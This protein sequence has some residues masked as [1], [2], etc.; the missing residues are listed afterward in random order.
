MRPTLFT[1][2]NVLTFRYFC[3]P[4]LCV[5][6]LMRPWGVWGQTGF[7]GGPVGDRGAFCSQ[8]AGVSSDRLGG[9][10][11]W[12][13]VTRGLSCPREPPWLCGQALLRQPLRKGHC[14]TSLPLRVGSEG[15]WRCLWQPFALHAAPAIKPRAT[16]EVFFVAGHLEASPFTP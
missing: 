16:L 7:I 11:R 5:F 6:D 1:P 12:S 10:G 3:C 9:R 13:P 15:A 4:P 2:A 8:P 14:H